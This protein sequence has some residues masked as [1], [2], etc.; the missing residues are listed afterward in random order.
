MVPSPW[1]RRSFLRRMHQGGAVAR[2]MSSENQV[3]VG[4]SGATSRTCSSCSLSLHSVCA[5]RL[6]GGNAYM[7]KSWAQLCASASVPRGP[8][9]REKYSWRWKDSWEANSFTWA[10]LDRLQISR[11]ISGWSRHSPG[12]V[13][14]RESALA[15]RLSFP[16]MWTC[17]ACRHTHRVQLHTEKRDYLH[18]RHTGGGAAKGSR[19][20]WYRRRC[21]LRHPHR[22][23][24]VPNGTG[25]RCVRRYI[26]PEPYSLDCWQKWVVGESEEAGRRTLSSH[27]PKNPEE[28]EIA[29]GPVAEQN[30]TK[31]RI[32][33]GERLRYAKIH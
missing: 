14:C 13:S 30:K 9:V 8:S 19:V 2:K 31:H 4:Q 28:K 27:G 3:R 33:L 24:W 22:T 11:I 25:Q 17:E 20:G 18:N 23:P 29:L 26:V 10:S 32:L 21:V 5:S 7:C 12:N 16:R 15:A 6:T 1:E